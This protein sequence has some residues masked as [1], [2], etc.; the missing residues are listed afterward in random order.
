MS[1]KKLRLIMY[2]VGGVT[3][4]LLE[5][6]VRFAGVERAGP[7]LLIAFSSIGAL[8]VLFIVFDLGYHAW[9]GNGYACR[10]CG[11]LRR[12]KAFRISGACPNC[13]EY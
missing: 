6:L 9:R 3:F 10:R 2:S 5:G 8:M 11:Y 1:W 7:R 13:G 12:M 4:S